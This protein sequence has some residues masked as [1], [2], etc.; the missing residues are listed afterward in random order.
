MAA[1][2]ST[3]HTDIYTDI[4]RYLLSLFPDNEVIQGYSNNVPLPNSPFILMNIITESDL[5]TQINEY[6]GN[7]QATAT[8]SVETALQ[9]DFYGTESGNRARIFQ[10]LWR[11]YHACEMLEKCRPLHADN[12]RYIP[13]ADEEQNFEER[14]NVTAYLTYNP[15]ITHS[16][17]YVQ[18][19][20]V[21]IQHID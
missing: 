16:Q 5:N 7:G 18:S 13:L 4:R 9:L 3:K 15:T 14:W 10:N 11:D 21:S 1:T 17:D 19:V 12:L 20:D 2:L 8:R 6:D